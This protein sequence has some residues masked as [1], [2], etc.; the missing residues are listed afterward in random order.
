MH[1][2]LL[3]FELKP[4][5]CPA[6]CLLFLAYPGREACVGLIRIHDAVLALARVRS[7]RRW[8]MGP[9]CQAKTGTGFR[10]FIRPHHPLLRVKLDSNS[11][12]E[13]RTVG[14]ARLLVCC[15][16]EPSGPLV[17][18]TLRDPICSSSADYKII[19]TIKP[20]LTAGGARTARTL[21][22]RARPQCRRPYRAMS[23]RHPSQDEVREMAGCN[24]VK[25]WSRDGSGRRSDTGQWVVGGRGPTAEAGQVLLPFR[26]LPSLQEAC[27]LCASQSSSSWRKK[28]VPGSSV[29]ASGTCAGGA[30]FPADC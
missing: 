20:P 8:R 7:R 29:C 28:I 1:S 18:P 22:P 6:R 17:L 10:A 5:Y 21:R 14:R 24:G 16:L 25:A 4:I 30:P 15:Q 19:H 23:M 3:E 13:S 27:V 2:H 12:P 26:T 11:A 9:P